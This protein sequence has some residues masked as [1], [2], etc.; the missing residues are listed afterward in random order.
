MDPMFNEMIP[1]ET[2]AVTAIQADAWRRMEEREAA[3]LQREAE[4]RAREQATI[5][6][7][8]T[9]AGSAALRGAR[10]AGLHIPKSSIPVT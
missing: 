2:Q 8:A 1:P 3:I 5:E 9:A 7:A 10:L 4:L 6:A